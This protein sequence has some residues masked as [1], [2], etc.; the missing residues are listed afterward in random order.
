M[1][2]GPGVVMPPTRYMVSTGQRP[3][4]PPPAQYV[5][6]AGPHVGAAYSVPGPRLQSPAPNAVPI[7]D[8]ALLGGVATTGRFV[9]QAPLHTGRATV[10]VGSFVGNSM[11][12]PA[13]KEATA[14]QP[15]PNGGSITVVG[16]PAAPQTVPAATAQAP[17][18]PQTPAVLTAR[19]PKPH[20]YFPF[21]VFSGRA[22]EGLL[23]KALED[24][25]SYVRDHCMVPPYPWGQVIYHDFLVNHVLKEVPGDLAEF[26]IGQGGTSVFF[27][28][29]AKQHRRK[30]LAVDSFEGLPE[31]DVGK[32][33][34]YFLPGDYRP[35]NQT[36]NYENFLRYKS[37]F[38]VDDNLHILQGFFRDV[39]I[40]EEFESFCFVHMDSDLYDSV[41][42]SLTKV[43][44]KLSH[45]G[46]IAVDDFFHHAQ[47]PARAVSDFFRNL[48]P[49]Q[50][51][52]LMFVVPTYAVLI[53]K[54][55]SACTQWEERS[56]GR[57][58]PVMHCPR[59]LDGNFYSFALMRACTP[60]VRAVE[61][62][63]QRIQ[64]VLSHLSGQGE[65][66]LALTR[67]KENAE[68]FLRFLRY[69]ESAPRS[70][71]DIMRYL[72]PLEDQFDIT[73]GNLCGMP[74]VE[75][76]TIEIRI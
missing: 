1:A 5:V 44:D 48:R 76:K 24:E 29:L 30:F 6:A 57:L 56:P 9:S 15:R 50:E 8:M 62:S 11:V 12:L 73:E 61:M 74:G 2:Q 37:R 66:K 36:D 41:Y 39:E 64:T 31:P 10:P 68:A 4:S 65:E 60:F 7:R 53:V 75:R 13:E 52:P 38:D 18:T 43:W 51:P 16:V 19:L 42:D 70:G 21:D 3:G 47:G 28:R 40:P 14:H 35:N 20:D 26:G 25:L 27:A 49:E 59:A 33:N 69:S 45:G 72:L 55:R 17:E 58:S 23:P 22:A 46:C 34:P 32:D 54:G 63:L 71:C 67:V